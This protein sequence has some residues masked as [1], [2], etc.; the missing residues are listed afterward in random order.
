MNQSAPVS[1]A[2]K[3]HKLGTFA[4]VFT[5]SIL[6]ILGIIL[7]RRVGYVVGIS[8]LAQTLAI[9]AFATLICILSSM[10]LSAIATNIRVK[11]GGDYYLISRT[12]GVEFGGA[13]GLVLFLAQAV[14][15][16]FY[17]IGFGEAVAGLGD[18]EHPWAVQLI[19]AAAV[20]ALFLP[21]WFGA[22][23]T[24][25]F[26]FVVMFVLAGA[27][28]AFFWGTSGTW[29]SAVFAESWFVGEGGGGFWIAFAIFFPAVTG[30]TQ[31]VSMSG[32]LRNPARSLPR[33][34][35]A[36][37]GLSTLVYLAVVLAY[38]GTLPTSELASNYEAMRGVARIPW[39]IDAGV[40]AAT[41]SSAMASFL[42]AP[43]ILQSL[44]SDKIF[45]FLTP[46]AKGYGPSENPRR[47][48]LL[49]AGIA[50]S[51]IMLGN[52]NVIAPVV[53]MFFL[54][55]YGL[56]NYATYYEAR[57]G[58]PSFRPR[59]RWFDQRL[60][61]GGALACLAAMLAIDVT[62]AIASAAIMFGIFQ[63]LKR[64]AGPAR[65]A[66]SSR[67]HHFR[68]IRENLLAITS[69]PEHPRDWRPHVLAMSDDE[70]RREKLMRFAS[71]IEGKTGLTTAVR[72]LAG[73]GPVIRQ[74]R[75]KTEDALRAEL[76][77]KKFQAFALCIS[78]PDVLLGA[79]ML[80]QAYGIGPL[81]ANT[82]LLN[83]LEQFPWRRDEDKERHYGSYL[84]AALRLKRNV[85]VL[86]A[87][88]RDWDALYEI[89]AAK[90]RIDVWWQDNATGRLL[91]L[92]A[93]LM[94]RT[95]TW[96][97]ASIRVIAAASPD[98]GMEATQDDVQHM[99]AD[100]RIDAEVRIID[101]AD[102]NSV[103]AQSADATIVLLPMRLKGDQ[104]LEP[105]GGP[106]ED[107]VSRLPVTALAIAGE[108][109]DLTAEPDEGQQ[110]EL[111]ALLDQAEDLERRAKEAE[112]IAAQA[113]EAAE[114]A[115]QLLWE[116]ASRG[117]HDELDQLRKQADE[118]RAAATE[119]AR[120]AAK[121]RAVAD[122][123]LCAIPEQ[124]RAVKPEV[125]AAKPGPIDG[126]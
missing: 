85:V 28:G 122:A 100:V 77:E 42:G 49:S 66:D 95:E 116:A 71:W 17:C 18:W 78:T 25:R 94:T 110:G 121:A 36:A 126:A 97:D 109:I 98:E 90:R 50:L 55:S 38:A 30:F 44:A 119:S 35:F 31:G 9:V 26:Q 54:I 32:D 123:A 112:N 57:A 107:L 45:R 118:A 27:I 11:K 92:M 19:A 1:E 104:P 64:T 20:T 113:A 53:S 14:S 115:V 7:F 89:P 83:W 74:E 43:R 70:P 23:V 76:A 93:Y 105:F 99:L 68:V 63:Y 40:V 84:R 117:T 48:V 3:S 33:G 21:A 56:L 47:G 73:D 124:Y 103:V 86:E 37:V 22:D 34:T 51:T 16:A 82:I 12:L 72:V 29:S 114:T 52:L 96:I 24:S 39:L 102:A 13:I 60:S 111:A 58:S 8:G 67:A 101:T 65:W 80:L 87:E 62:A 125:D 75:A 10:S 5:P 61:L 2:D 46:F 88:D 81:R 59:F 106:I 108:Q 120:K 15:I 91:L 79:R 41:L 69:V 6:T 4:G